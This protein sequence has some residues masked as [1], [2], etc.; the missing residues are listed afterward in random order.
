MYVNNSK[1]LLKSFAINVV[2]YVAI[3]YKRIIFRHCCT[4]IPVIFSLSVNI[5]H[6]QGYHE[7]AIV[8]FVAYYIVYY[9]IYQ[10]IT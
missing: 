7:K 9:L 2:L 10:K 5:S 8:Y 3:N 1:D 4:Y 6:C